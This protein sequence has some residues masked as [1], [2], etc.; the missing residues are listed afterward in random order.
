MPSLKTIDRMAIAA[1]LLTA[2]SIPLASHAFAFGTDKPSATIQLRDG[3]E[4]RFYTT[5][6]MGTTTQR[7]DVAPG[8]QVVARAQVLNDDVF[9]SIHAGMPESEVFE[10]LGPP[11]GKTRFDATRTVAW[12]Y[13]Y[14]DTW[15]YMADF[16]VS[17]NEAGAVVGKFSAREGD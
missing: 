1:M 17:F 4:R 2:V 10:L 15:G 8:G 16:S 14:R 9:R 11:F 7:V 3:V 5:G 13:H 12:D 6:P